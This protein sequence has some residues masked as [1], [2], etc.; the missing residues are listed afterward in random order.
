MRTRKLFL[1]LGGCI[2]FLGLAHPTFARRV[3]MGSDA[4][5]DLS[6]A[7]RWTGRMGIRTQD[8]ANLGLISGGWISSWELENIFP[9]FGE[10]PEEVRQ[11]LI[12]KLSSPSLSQKEIWESQEVIK[13]LLLG[14]PASDKEGQIIF[15]KHISGLIEEYSKIKDEFYKQ[16]EYLRD[17]HYPMHWSGGIREHDDPWPEVTEPLMHLGQII[18]VLQE[19]IEIIPNSPN[20]TL[21]RWKEN[22]SQTL[23]RPELKPFLEKK[24]FLKAVSHWPDPEFISKNEEFQKLAEELS[25]LWVISQ[26][27]GGGSDKHPYLRQ[28]P[29]GKMQ[30]P[31]AEID[32]FSRMALLV[33]EGNYKFPAAAEGIGTINLASYIN[34]L[35][36][37]K[38]DIQP[39]SVHL[40]RKSNALLLSGPNMGGKTTTAR[41]VGLA[42]LL[43]QMGLST[44]DSNPELSLFRNIYTIFPRPEQLQKGYGY[45]GTLIKQLTELVQ[46][47]GPGDLVILDE[48]PTG[49]DYQELVAIATV[50]IEDLIN[51]GATVIATGHLK[52]AFKLLAERTGQVP[53]MH[54]VTTV[55]GRVTPDFHLEK[56]VAAHSYAIELTQEAGMPKEITEL[57][58]IY[59]KTITE[60]LKTVDIP[61]FTVT[62]TGDT[63][64]LGV[65]QDDK[66]F[67]EVFEK[68]YPE[69]NFAFRY[70]TH[71]LIYAIFTGD[72]QSVETTLEVLKGVVGELP[73]E[74]KGLERHSPLP[75]EAGR[76]RTTTTAFVN[77]GK[78]HLKELTQILASFSDI[79]E[80][81][82]YWRYEEYNLKKNMQK[83]SLLEAFLGRLIE[84]LN[85]V[86]KE[87]PIKVE[88][89]YLRKKLSGLADL[90][91]KYAGKDGKGLSDKELKSLQTE[92]QID[93]H[94]SIMKNLEIS[95]LV[96]DEYTGIARG[97]IK[98]GL[99]VPQFS[100]ERNIFSLK[101]S[102]PFFP[103]NYGSPFV[104]NAVPQSFA[105]DPNKPAMV[106]TGP[107]SS[108]KSVLMFNSWVNSL[109]AHNGFYVSGDLVTSKFDNIFAFFGGMNDVTTGE[110]YFMNILGKYANI[111]NSVTPNS[112]VILDELHG[113]DNFELAALQL[114]VL[115]YLRKLNATVIFNTHIRDGLKLA[116]EKIG[117]DFW[118]T[119]V[120]YDD[121][122]NVVTPLY[123]VSPDPNLEAKS[124]GLA[125]ASQWLSPAQI[126][127][128]KEILAQL[129]AEKEEDPE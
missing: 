92:W 48:V 97:V 116:A 106:I 28:F 43:N 49:T 50:L 91:Q 90:R 26:Q 120:K 46:K 78:E 4:H 51:K 58:R 42:V 57:A 129:Q 101:E 128:V 114:A 124:Y 87:E 35:L 121:V 117:L 82:Y 111:I 105:I 89:E 70:K 10:A 2:L 30:S 99:K 45:F 8:L 21:E 107:N 110:S 3:R 56:G 23:A 34:P 14:I 36:Q 38:T 52:K 40:T 72:R 20:P 65:P 67:K 125:V 7:P 104:E 86:A 6:S 15:I 17:K 60:D 94:Y 33:L 68:A 41:G 115:T 79:E 88:I 25:D 93:W 100:Q 127:R 85:P 19:L 103:D 27:E 123:T 66:M 13:A 31:L 119:D 11:I 44:P 118:K 126:Q 74:M 73:K 108:G 95:L 77:M 61:P 29:D 71:K 76:Y 54:T 39:I 53:F 18:I 98:N 122:K 62:T 96:I 22:I 83:I 47:A 112:L 69:E 59:Y 75:F 32:Y 113:T 37:E 55:D 16:L 81:G 63:E 80:R 109:F 1:I 12:R 24:D 84:Y 102:K 9:G 64:L 5:L